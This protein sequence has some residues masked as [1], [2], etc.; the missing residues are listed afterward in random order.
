M[1]LPTQYAE[2]I[3]QIKNNIYLLIK[4]NNA[5]EI[6]PVH[7]REAFDRFIEGWTEI[8]NDIYSKLDSV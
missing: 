3:Q 1:A 6:Q 7:V 2:I 8:E 4:D 5:K